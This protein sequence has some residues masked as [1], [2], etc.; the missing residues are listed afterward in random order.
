MSKPIRMFESLK[1]AYLRYYDSA[2][3]LRFEEVVQERR[4]L[5]DR[6]GVLYREPLVEPQPAYAG[7]GHDVRAAVCDVLSGADGWTAAVADDL[8]G[9][10]EE[11]LF[12]P[13]SGDP[14][15]LYAHQVDMLRASARHG[16]DTVILT[17]TGSGKTE[18][19]Y[20]P[21]LAALAKESAAWQALGPAPQ[22]D[23]WAMDPPPSSRRRRYHPRIAQR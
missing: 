4:R 23:W 19:I 12:L 6:D 21:V 18:A 17:G 9:I 7:S 20:L 16:S 14:I 11:G 3:D 1:N 2:F 8:A 13:S 22:N 10:A 5:L 15:E